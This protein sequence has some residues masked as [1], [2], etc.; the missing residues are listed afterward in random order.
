MISVSLPV[1]I[2]L[3]DPLLLTEAVPFVVTFIIPFIALT[4]ELAKFPSISVVLIPV[5]PVAVSSTTVCK[6]GTVFSGASL[7]G[8]TSTVT[9]PVAVRA[10]SDT[11]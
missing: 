1:I 7:T 10:P 8:I 3:P 9:E 2:I 6:P 11:V 4:S 5:I